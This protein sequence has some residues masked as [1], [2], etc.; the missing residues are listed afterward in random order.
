M[1][2]IGFVSCGD[3]PEP[4]PEPQPQGDIEGTLPGLFSI[5]PNK[6][7]YFSKGN[8]QYQAST[9]T[10]RFAPTQYTMVG[11]ANLNIS[12]SYGGWIDCF[13]WA[14]SGWEGGANARYMPY[15]YDGTSAEYNPGSSLV[16]DNAN[17]DWGV[18]NAISNGGNQA[19]LWRTLTL[20]EWNYLTGDNAKRADKWA[21]GTIEQTY[22]GLILLPDV[23]TMPDGLTCVTGHTEDSWEANKYSLIEWS[24]MEDAGAVF[25]PASGIRSSNT[26]FTG[27][28][29]PTLFMWLSTIYE[30]GEHAY[31]TYVNWWGVR[32]CDKSDMNFGL[33]VRLVRDKN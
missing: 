14:T 31:S 21:M 33:S 12:P 24:M 1:L 28:S 26:L 16:G 27:N 2:S 6:Q 29:D 15:E 3:D 9:R 25:I 7:V 20:D 30:T 13:G 23:F 22:A 5:S 18:F 4:T 32:D 17:C 8:L 11:E 19:G 10:F